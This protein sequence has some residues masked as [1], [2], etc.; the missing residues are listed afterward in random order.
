MNKIWQ[1]QS[2]CILFILCFSIINNSNANENCDIKIANFR[3]TLPPEV[4]RSTAGYGVI[5]NLGDEADTL[6]KIRSNAATVMLHK[7]EIVSGMA[8]MI[9]MSNMVIEPGSELVLEPMS[10]HLMLFNM[11]AKMIK[12]G[13]NINLLF[14][15][16]NAG[17]IEIEV[18]IRQ[19]WE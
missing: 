12:K 7:T 14:E 17:V 3:V 13:G 5:K 11:D 1:K 4:S 16:E 9:H 19:S 6:I 15:F 8:K 10:F 2:V 18:P